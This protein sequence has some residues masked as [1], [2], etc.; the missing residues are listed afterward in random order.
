MILD[1]ATVDAD[2][3]LDADVCVIG[4]G[5]GGAVAA[6]DSPRRGRSVVVVEDGRSAAASSQREELMYPRLVAKVDHGDRRVHRAR[7]PR[8]TVGSTV[9]GFFQR[10]ARR[11]PSCAGSAPS[12]RRLG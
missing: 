5:A 7:L 3:T 10:G 4:S 9:P 11:A 1:T 6:R 12:I 2:V 8:T